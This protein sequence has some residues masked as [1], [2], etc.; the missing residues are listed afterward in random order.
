MDMDSDLDLGSATL[1]GGFRVRPMTQAFPLTFKDV[2]TLQ[3]LVYNLRTW[4]Y[5]LGPELAKELNRIIDE[6]NRELTR[7]DEDI[8]GTKD[9]W[10]NLFNAF[11]ANVIEELEALND[12]AMSNLI[13]T[14]TSLTR[15]EL[16]KLYATKTALD[17]LNELV[18]TGRLSV[19][20]VGKSIE[21]KTVDVFVPIQNNFVKIGVDSLANIDTS[22][23]SSDGGV[24]AI[25]RK[26][27]GDA[28]NV[29]K[30]IAIGTNAMRNTQKSLDNTA[31]G[32]SA[33][34]N[35]SADKAEYDQSSTAGTRNVAIGGNAGRFVTGGSQHT[36][37]GRNA[38]QNVDGGAG[39]VAIGN[40]ASAG[41]CPVG[42][43]GTVENWAPVA[44]GDANTQNIVAVGNWAASRNTSQNITA[45]GAYAL[46]NSVGA[47]DNVAVGANSL[48]RIDE[49]RFLTGD[50]YDN[51]VRTGTYTQTGNTLT[52]NIAN[53]GVSI[54]DIV[55]FKLLDGASKTFANDD[56]FAEVLTKPSASVVTVRHPVARSAGGAVR[57]AGFAKSGTAGNHSN[58]NTA[59]GSAS[60]AFLN[61]GLGG[62]TA[63]GSDSGRNIKTGGNN[64]SLGYNS[65]RG[66]SEASEINVSDNTA[67]GN[68]SLY[69]ISDGM[70]GNS[71][72]G[73]RSG[74]NLREGNNNTFIGRLA[75]AETFTG[76]P[77]RKVTGSTA[78]GAGS[79]VS[80][81]NQVQ[82]GSSVTT[83][84]AYGAIQNRSDIRDKSE[85]RD[86]VLGLGFIESVRPVDF[87]YNYRE[88]EGVGARFHHGVI[89]Q[90]ISEI[91][92]TT[93]VDFGGYQDHTLSGGA[94]VMSVGYTEFIGPLIKAVQE[95]SARVKELE[96]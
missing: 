21:D 26:A 6:V 76:E 29:D 4:C 49:N 1:G 13:K 50:L 95:L 88:G 74:L 71:M 44:P 85:V 14:P 38:G 24:V 20:G 84:Y 48:R 11:M 70:G 10:E 32:D 37:M 94:D 75:G 89:A 60:L 8:K 92:K 45:V 59:V 62:N 58:S 79:S 68:G 77:L 72:L 54:G 78:L 18:T 47:L 22:I 53:N 91:I 23:V 96:G 82:L 69:E 90:E 40:G 86:T 2:I 9:S 51:T 57:L 31:I 65:M 63:I 3:E 73:Y 12:Q 28:T 7:Q 52:L 35:V 87:K 80:G 67:I 16:N 83:T 81:D 41:R 93:G 43:S 17:A 56:V 55:V 5:Q 61:G 33:L 15:V 46:T 27:L 66:I 25:G 64:T 19:S 34:R 36:F 30:S 39:I 42:L